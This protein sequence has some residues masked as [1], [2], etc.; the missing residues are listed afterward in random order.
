[1]ELFGLM[2]YK[3]SRCWRRK[4]LNFPPQ[5]FLGIL[6]DIQI[7]ITFRIDPSIS[8]YNKSVYVSDRPVDWTFLKEPQFLFPFVKWNHNV[9]GPGYMP[10]QCNCFLPKN[11]TLCA[12]NLGRCCLQGLSWLQ[13]REAS[14]QLG[15]C[16]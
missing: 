5:Y 7:T 14:G 15:M 16:V 6:P 13:E 8:K 1:M 3:E 2:V 10:G 4:R 12:H 9:S 11:E